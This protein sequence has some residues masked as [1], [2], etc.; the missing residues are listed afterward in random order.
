MS[1]TAAGPLTRVVLGLRIAA[2]IVACGPALVALGTGA[3]TTRRLLGGLLGSFAPAGVAALLLLALP[4]WLAVS[5]WHAGAHRAAAWAFVAGCA[6]TVVAGTLL[7]ARY[8][9]LLTTGVLIAVVGAAVVFLAAASTTA[10]S[11]TAGSPR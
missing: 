2:V 10:A 7:V 1:L 3:G 6:V 8:G 4:V 9:H 11:T 5:G